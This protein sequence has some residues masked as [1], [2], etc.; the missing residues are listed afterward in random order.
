MKILISCL[1]V[2]TC[3][4]STLCAQMQKSITGII[5]DAETHLPLQGVSI[6]LKHRATQM[7][8]SGNGTFRMEAASNIDTLVISHIGYLT[9]EIAINSLT[10]LSSVNI[11][12]Q[13]DARALQEVIINTGFQQLPKERAT[14]SFDLI[15]NKTLNLQTGS[16]ILSRLNGVASGVLFDDTK[17]KSVNRKLGINVRGLSTINGSQDPLIILDNFPY[18]GDLSNIN[19]NDVENISVLKDAAAASIWGSRAGNGVIVITTKKGKLNQPLRIEFNSNVSMSKKPD[20]YDLPQMRSSDYIDVEKMLFDNGYI[21][22][23][24]VTA[25]SPAIEIFQKKQDGL[26]T[27]NQANAAIEALKKKDVRDDYSMYFYQPSFTQQYSLGLRGGTPNLAWYL[28][29]GYDKNIGNL[30]EKNDRVTLRLEN[31]YRPAQN[32]TITIGALYTASAATS[33]KPSYESIRVNYRPI[34]YLSFADPSGSPLSVAMQYRDAFTDTAGAGHLLDWKYYPLN[35]YKHNN[36]RNSLQNI[37]ANVGLQ[38]QLLKGLNADIRYNYQREQQS[39]NTLH[40]MQSYYTRNMINDFSQVDYDAGTVNYIVPMG[41]IQDMSE[42]VV[43]SHNA[44]AQLNYNATFHNHSVAAITGAE[45]RQ[46]TASSN[47]RTIYGYDDDILTTGTVDFRNEYPSVSSGSTAFIPDGVTFAETLNRY[48]SLF[49]NAAYT[50]RE[51][52]TLSASI[53]K[54]AS[55]LFGVSTN[56]KWK[57]FW[58]AGAAWNI[59]SENFYS[60]SL[61][62]VLKLR[63]TYGYSGTVD[64]HKSAV[65]VLTASGNNRYTGFPAAQVTQY[66]NAELRW[67]KVATANIGL[68]FAISKQR[69]SGSIEYYRKKGLDLFGPSPVDYTAGLNS[70]TVVRNIANMQ[71]SGI[72]INLQSKN[73]DRSFK[74]QTGLLFSLYTDKTTSYYIPAGSVYR[75]GFGTDISPMIDKPLYAILSY[76]SAGLDPLTGDPQGYLNKTI[77]KDY[78]AMSVAATATDSLAFSG[79]ATPKFFGA[80]AN[81]FSWKGFSLSVNITYKLGYYFRKSSIAY[82]RLFDYGIGHSDFARRWQQPGDEKITQVPSMLFPAEYGRDDFYLL[83]EATVVKGDHIRLQFVNLSYDLCQGLFGKSVFRSLQLYFNASNLGILWKANSQRVDPEFP[84][85]I[86]PTK[87]YTIGLRADL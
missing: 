38:Y 48:V 2:L 64:Q 39:L 46:T 58:S 80:I 34:P 75:P 19:P 56:D 26:L 3:F 76:K 54:D 33:G 40:D 43:V 87:T 84:D 18:E 61:V 27:E 31:T 11:I 4:I 41:V 20:L 35:E 55:N 13:K 12:L 82:D 6:T 47:T 62:P 86:V 78:Y 51:K 22:G 65:T 63:L 21:S 30:N 45:L 66:A 5:R 24:G 50:Y 57:P 28:S 23:F 68:D 42:A 77:S 79:A 32:L 53:R 29:G 83:S 8:S 59:A 70:N 17:N 36:T 37:L 60:S 67:E 49:G 72:D 9:Q 14:G 69:I 71:A 16:T 73:I 85:S 74:W 81:S 10:S 25:L 44:R 15:D 52:Y 1:L 7:I